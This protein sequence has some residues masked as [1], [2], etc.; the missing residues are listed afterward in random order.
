M[1]IPLAR[2][3]SFYTVGLAAPGAVAA[4]GARIGDKVVTVA[5]LTTPGSAAAT[6]ETVITVDDQIQQTGATDLSAKQLL[7]QLT[8]V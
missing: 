6:F 8:R 4:V 1:A 3:L 7:I 5:N 2:V